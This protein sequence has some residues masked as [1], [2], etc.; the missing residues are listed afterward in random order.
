METHR[1]RGREGRGHP[2][3]F[4]IGLVCRYIC[5][6]RAWAWW[7]GLCISGTVVLART[8]TIFLPLKS[9]SLLSSFTASPTTYVY[10]W[11]CTSAF[12][13]GGG[14]LHK[15][16]FNRMESN[17]TITHRPTHLLDLHAAGDLAPN[18]DTAELLL[19]EGGVGGAAAED[20]GGAVEQG[21][22][23]HGWSCC[24]GCL[25]VELFLL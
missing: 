10:I 23:G 16:L 12:G 18:A 1:A 3:L 21:G 7:F 9:S 4:R 8:S 19:V 5:R 25:D 22:G 6:L 11:T 13:L 24:W 14:V 2:D 20:G 17:T 15:D